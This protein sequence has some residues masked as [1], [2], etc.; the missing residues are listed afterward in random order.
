MR[1]QKEKLLFPVTPLVF[2]TATAWTGIVPTDLF[3][4]PFRRSGTARLDILL[5]MAQNH[6]LWPGLPHFQFLGNSLSR[7]LDGKELLH[8]IFLDTMNHLPEHLE[9]LFLIF[10]QRVLLPV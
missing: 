1:N 4:L 2:L 8:H 10:L 3:A 6:S 7:Q 5:A 9:P